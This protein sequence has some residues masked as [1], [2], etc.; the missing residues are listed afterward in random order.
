M[1]LQSLINARQHN[2]CSYSMKYNREHSC[3]IREMR[4]SRASEMRADIEQV[5]LYA[6][7]ITLQIKITE[8]TKDRV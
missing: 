4:A 3:D 6:R 2:A 8:M 7:E 5:F 1:T